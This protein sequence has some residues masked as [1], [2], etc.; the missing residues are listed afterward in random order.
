MLCAIVF[1]QPTAFTSHAHSNTN[2][3]SSMLTIDVIVVALNVNVIEF[4]AATAKR[5]MMSQRQLS[6]KRCTYQS[7]ICGVWLW[8][9]IESKSNRIFVQ[10]NS[11]YCRLD[12]VTAQASAQA[13]KS[14]D[15]SFMAEA[16]NVWTDTADVFCIRLD[17]LWPEYNRC[18]RWIS[19]CTNDKICRAKQKKLEANFGRYRRGKT[20]CRNNNTSC[21]FGK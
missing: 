10:C 16:S 21:I 13:S 4:S 2:K 17:T 6:G 5:K 14:T 9:T 3:R 1:V 7:I 18:F 8:N 11:N 20:T 15:I 19:E 12:K